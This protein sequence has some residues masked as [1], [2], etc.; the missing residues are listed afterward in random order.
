MRKLAAL[1]LVF[2]FVLPAPTA[3]A[4]VTRAQLAEAEAKAREKSGEL[5]GRL[6]ELESAQYQQWLYEDRID[7]LRSQIADR[8]RRLALAGLAAREQAVYLYMNF[9]SHRDSSVLADEEISRAG[10]RD[11]YMRTLLAADR[12]A[13]NELEYLKE[14]A[15]RLRAE[16]EDLLVTQ[17][18]A[19]AELERQTGLLLGEL[20]EAN[21]EFQALYDQWWREEQERIRRAEAPRQAALAAEAA[22]AAA[23]SGYA[24]S[25]GTPSAG[26][27]CAVAGPNTFRD[28]WGEPRPGGRAHHGLD[29]VAANGTPLVAVENGV[30]YGVGWHYL[31]GNNLYV[32]GDSSDVYYYAHLSGFAAGIGDGVRVNKGQL[33][34]YVGATGNAGVPHLHLGY[35]PAGGPLTNP[36]QLM[37]RLCR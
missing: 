4:E 36:Y 1:V 30:V 19:S 14:D 7:G 26:R 17:G 29:M 20:E 9:G 18:E 35:Q 10:T 5:E 8:E 3:V 27:T 12:D 34:G 21:A 28:S 11:A 13:V 24:S 16:L 37:A 25:A 23:A 6:A 33:I 31:G 32:R 22:A 15:E 2:L